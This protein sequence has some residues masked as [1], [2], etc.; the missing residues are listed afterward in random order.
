MCLELSAKL[1]H[2]ESYILGSTVASSIQET[3]KRI[4]AGSE[5]PVACVALLV[6][7]M[8]SENTTYITNVAS[9][10]GSGKRSRSH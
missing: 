10:I 5:A 6:R 2:G 3:V 7:T 1:L 9:H 4:L 8:H